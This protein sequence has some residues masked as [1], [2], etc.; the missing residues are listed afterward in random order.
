MKTCEC[1]N[2]FDTRARTCRACQ[3]WEEGKIVTFDFEVCDVEADHQLSEWTE[4]SRR[5]L[6][7]LKKF[8]AEHPEIPVHVVGYPM[9]LMSNG[10]AVTEYGVHRVV[11]EAELEE[12][13]KDEP[14]LELTRDVLRKVTATYIMRS[15]DVNDFT[16]GLESMVEGGPT[17][18]GGYDVA[19]IGEEEYANH[20]EHLKE[21]FADE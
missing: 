18:T 15:V 12:L 1:G 3:W 11:T 20:E 14:E 17:V 10:N 9:Y 19:E 5:A 6:K 8:R 7:Y 4:S 13:A 2:E 21:V 16:S